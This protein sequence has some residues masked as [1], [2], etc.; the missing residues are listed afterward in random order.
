M[1]YVN[2]EQLINEINKIQ[3]KY[4]N[5]FEDKMNCI[6]FDGDD[7]SQ[8]YIDIYCLVHSK[9]IILSQSF[10]VFS[11]FSS[12]VNKAELYY[13]LEHNKMNEFSKSYENIKKLHF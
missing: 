1:L 7:I 9:K 4:I 11:I 2:I 5:M 6:S 3:S 10:S 12:L 13:L 8:T